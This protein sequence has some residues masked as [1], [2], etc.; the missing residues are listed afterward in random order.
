MENRWERETDLV[1]R[2]R[3]CSN[4]CRQGTLKEN[5]LCNFMKPLEGS[6]LRSITYGIESEVVKLEMRNG[7]HCLQWGLVFIQG[8]WSSRS[9]P[10]LS[11]NCRFVFCMD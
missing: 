1:K 5:K 9:S 7:K 2:K 8:S 4:V 6:G 10:L 3:V 11:E